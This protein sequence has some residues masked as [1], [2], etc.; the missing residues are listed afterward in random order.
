MQI[1]LTER[2][3]KDLSALSSNQ[4]NSLFSIIL[5]LPLAIKNIHQHSGLG[6][7]KIHSS[8]IFEARLG[9]GL[10][11]VFGFQNNEIILHRIGS[12]EEIKRYLKMLS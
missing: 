3:Q 9:L 8:G 12:H 10:R 11:L 5:K 7:R 2:F 4:Q 1:T 6:L